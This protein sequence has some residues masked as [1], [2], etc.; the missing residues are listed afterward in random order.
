MTNKNAIASERE[1]SHDQEI[2]IVS[3]LTHKKIAIASGGA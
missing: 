1:R 2:T 3:N